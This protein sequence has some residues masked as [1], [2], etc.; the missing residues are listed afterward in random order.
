M[1]MMMTTLP[2]I[3]TISSH[4]S[5]RHLWHLSQ[6]LLLKHPNRTTQAPRRT[7]GSKG[8]SSAKAL[9]SLN[10]SDFQA[11]SFKAFS[12]HAAKAHRRK[13]L[14]EK[15]THL[16]LLSGLGREWSL[17]SLADGFES[18]VWRVLGLQLEGA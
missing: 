18:V 17:R 6:L 13:T 5:G 12:G 4:E 9:A 15:A 3:I 16:D 14:S 7:S 2:I 10:L 11:R 1:E 8:R